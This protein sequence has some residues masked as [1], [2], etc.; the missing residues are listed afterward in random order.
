MIDIELCQMYSHPENWIGALDEYQCYVYGQPSM[1]FLSPT[2]CMTRFFKLYLFGILATS[3]ATVAADPPQFEVAAWIDHF[4]FALHYDT[5]TVPGLS[6]ILDHAEEAGSNTIWWRTHSGGRV[7]YQS[8]LGPGFHHDSII[9]KRL[10]FD[11]RDVYGWVHYGETDFDMLQEVV[12]MCRQRGL[13]VGVHWPFE[14]AHFH[15]FSL[16]QF[17]LENPQYWGRAEDGSLR[18]SFCSI[19][20]E[21]VI[22]FRLA[23]LDE[24]LKRGI[25]VLYLDFMR[26][27]YN[28]HFE[29]VEPIQAA[30][31]G[32]LWNKHAFGYVT[33]YMRRIRKHLDA[34]GR[35][36]ELVVGI[37]AFQSGVKDTSTGWDWLEWI[38]EGLVDTLNIIWVAWDDKDP[39]GS[40]RALYREAVQ[41]VDGRCRV[42]LPI[43]QY[44]HYA[45]RGLPAYERVS[46]KTQTEVASELMLIAHDVGADGVAL[47]CLDYNNYVPTTRRAIKEAAE[48][49]CHFKKN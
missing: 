19:G 32:G 43:R 30:Y 12:R 48:G 26:T 2:F 46:G 10:G 33:T 41:L 8:Q 36:V 39:F 24:M 38:D 6:A 28:P 44:N 13:K 16:G 29:H 11:T 40:T 23:L 20:H 9:D 14:E 37:P 3:G 18:M 1:S 7:R 17:N 15:S 27:T 47:E 25:D 4:D 21:K 49:V 22:Q 34:S 42:L 5:E 31:Q 35:K 45:A